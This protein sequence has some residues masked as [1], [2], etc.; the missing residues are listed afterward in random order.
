VLIWCRKT[1]QVKQ[2]TIT[3][4]CHFLALRWF[5]REVSVTVQ[6]SK[7]T[8]NN[9][10][11]DV[12]KQNML[13]HQSDYIL[14]GIQ[15]SLFMFNVRKDFHPLW[16]YYLSQVILVAKG[17]TRGKKGR[18]IEGLYTRRFE[19]GG[20]FTSL[21]GSIFSAP[22]IPAVHHS[23][24]YGDT[25][26]VFLTAST[27]PARAT[28]MQPDRHSDSKG[29]SSQDNSGGHYSVFCRHRSSEALWYDRTW[30]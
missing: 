8:L 20:F 28:L 21:V 9:S 24:A 3:V 11:E 16:R 30:E 17:E 23:I 27:T 10:P 26:N 4:R 2:S 18:F 25:A 1:R 13:R 14:H 6:R 15:M 22:K 7:V 12:M 19:P 5:A 29:A